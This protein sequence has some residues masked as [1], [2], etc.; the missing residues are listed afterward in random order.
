[1]GKGDPM[2]LKPA[3]SLYTNMISNKA[4]DQLAAASGHG[5]WA[6]ELEK[7]KYGMPFYFKDLRDGSM[8]YFRAYLSGISEAI[9]PTWESQNYIGRSEPV[10]T[11]TGAEREINFTLKLFANTKD[12]LDQIYQKMNRLT[13]LCYPEYKEDEE[14]ELIGADGAATGRKLKYGGVNS[15]IRM[16]PPMT[17]FRLGELFGSSPDATTGTWKNKDNETKTSSHAE[18]VGFIK[19]LSYNF[20]DESPWE[21]QRGYRVPKFVEAEISYQVIHT[22][23]PSLEFALKSEIGNQ[24]TFYGINK[25]LMRRVDADNGIMGVAEQ[26]K[27]FGG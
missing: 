25:A 14:W 26:I 27:E 11:Y 13:S 5:T 22:K 6:S 9:S 7:E 20:P 16:K 8:L 19:S 21:I 17:K 23:V 2:T 10:Y 12:E 15:R 18:M 4:K 3:H 24:K 1:M